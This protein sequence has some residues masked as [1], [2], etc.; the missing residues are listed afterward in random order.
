MD[1]FGC[2]SFLKEKDPSFI[3]K[4]ISDIYEIR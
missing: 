4:K 1:C 2:F 3:L